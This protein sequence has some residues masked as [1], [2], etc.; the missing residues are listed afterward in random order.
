MKVDHIAV[1]TGDLNQLK[2]F[3]INYFGAKEIASYQEEG[4]KFRSCFLEFKDSFK[5][6]IMQFEK[7][8]KRP[9]NLNECPVGFTHLAFKVG[10]KSE[11]DSLTDKFKEDG[12]KLEK[13]PLFTADGFY[14]SAVFDPDG[15]I[16]EITSSK[17][18][19]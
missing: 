17:N 10:S 1:W 3:Y 8:K 19:Y 14:E 4:G 5:L 18:L 7:V 13:E 12:F 11:V 2:D 9:Y 15:N 6:E 16:I